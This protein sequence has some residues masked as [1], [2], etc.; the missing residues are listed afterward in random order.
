MKFH[1]YNDE[2]V[3]PDIQ[4]INGDALDLPLI[5]T[6]LRQQ[7]ND[8]PLVTLRLRARHL[9]IVTCNQQGWP[10]LW[11][12]AHDIIPRLRVSKIRFESGRDPG[13]GVV[14]ID[15]QLTQD[16]VATVE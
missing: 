3:Q 15:I 11:F 13:G 1:F 16:D 7:L 4:D 2:S 12:E 14:E 6:I 9:S 5:S 10:E 8:L